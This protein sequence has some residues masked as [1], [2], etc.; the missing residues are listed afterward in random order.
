MIKCNFCNFYFDLRKL[1]KNSF[2]RCDFDDH[3]DFE[4]REQYL[5]IVL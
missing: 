4:V 5:D 1:K 3:F 2:L